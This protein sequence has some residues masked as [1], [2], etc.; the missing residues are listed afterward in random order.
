MR[1]VDAACYAAKKGGG[2]RVHLAVR[3]SG[4]ESTGRNGSAAPN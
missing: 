3:R 4:A 1:V 2:N